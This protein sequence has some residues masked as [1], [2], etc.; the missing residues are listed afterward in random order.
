[1]RRGFSSYGFFTGLILGVLVGVLTGSIALWMAIGVVLGI[2][3]TH[4][5]FRHKL[6]RK[7]EIEI[8]PPQRRG[9]RRQ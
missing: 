1:M 8:I 9:M 4:A 5:R 6:P 2:A 7:Q 3:I